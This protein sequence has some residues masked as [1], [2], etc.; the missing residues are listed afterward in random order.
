[1][2]DRENDSCIEAEHFA[3]LCSEEAFHKW[4]YENFSIWN[5]DRLV[6]LCDDWDVLQK[7]IDDMGLPQDIYLEF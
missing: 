5:G 4:L 6:Q 1:M 3:Y 7:Y 2:Y